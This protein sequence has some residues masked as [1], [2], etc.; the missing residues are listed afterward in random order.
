MNVSKAIHGMA[1]VMLVSWTPGCFL[2]GSP[3][4]DV[5]TAT[6]MDDGRIVVVVQTQ[7]PQDEAGDSDFRGLSRYTFT[8]AGETFCD[9]IVGPE[10][11][12]GYGPSYVI[13]GSELLITDTYRETIWIA[14]DGSSSGVIDDALPFGRRLQGAWTSPDGVGRVATTSGI[15]SV[16]GDGRVA[17]VATLGGFDGRAIQALNG[18]V[19]TDDLRGVTVRCVGGITPTETLIEV[20][21]TGSRC[22]LASSGVAAD[23]RCSE[24]T[25]VSGADGAYYVEADRGSSPAIA[26]TTLDGRRRVA[27][28]NTFFLAATPREGGGVAIASLTYLDT[29]ELVLVDPDGTVRR[30]SMGSHD[31]LSF[32]DSFGMVA[33]GTGADEEVWA[34]LGVGH[35]LRV[36]SIGVE[37]GEQLQRRD[38]PNCL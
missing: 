15:F 34:F 36:V 25:L 12:A 23:G 19:P 33:I 28:L 13:T 27:D 1:L 24:G 16:T 7:G 26:I 22:M 5:R 14:A 35:G 9:P 3:T 30:A 2:F 21:C 8:R 32:L 20:D 29:L 18:Y 4:N 10:Q 17:S 37:T 31:A 11:P 6:V 38:L